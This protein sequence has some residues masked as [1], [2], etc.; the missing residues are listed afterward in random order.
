[1]VGD[2]ILE[3]PTAQYR[4]CKTNNDRHKA[5]TQVPPGL[6]HTLDVG[7]HFDFINTI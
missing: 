7:I 2:P 6:I 4:A 3:V 1:M 5:T